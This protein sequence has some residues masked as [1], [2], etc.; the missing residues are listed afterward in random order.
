MLI[1]EHLAVVIS[2]TSA[3]SLDKYIW[4]EFVVSI[5]SVGAVPVT[6]T[7]KLS[8]AVTEMEEITEST[9]TAVFLQ[10][11]SVIAL[12]LP[13]ITTVEF[14]HANRLTVWLRSVSSIVSV[15][16]SWYS[17]NTVRQ[18]LHPFAQEHNTYDGPFAAL[19][20][21]LGWLLGLEAL[22]LARERRPFAYR[23]RRLWCDA[24]LRTQLRVLVGHLALI[25]LA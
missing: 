1:A 8:E 13:L 12:T 2:T 14:L 24:W 22:R 4:P 19:E 5:C 7:V 11:T 21:K 9:S 23:T 20:H 6:C 18:R 3:H 17:Y 10:F 25:D 15:S 16:P